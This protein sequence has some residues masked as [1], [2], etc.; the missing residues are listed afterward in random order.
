M[1]ECR[2]SV[3]SQ[4]PLRVQS[5]FLKENHDHSFSTQSTEDMVWL[6]V[7]FD[8]QNLCLLHGPYVYLNLLPKYPLT[9]HPRKI[10]HT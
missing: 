4:N 3:R 2:N 8:K 10:L 6:Y 1:H 5:V 9:S 7:R